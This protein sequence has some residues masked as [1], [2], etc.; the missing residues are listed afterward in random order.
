MPKLEKQNQ[1]AVVSHSDEQLLWPLMLHALRGRWGLAVTMSLI[2]CICGAMILYL[3]LVPN[4]RSEGMIRL[5]PKRVSAFSSG[6]VP[7]SGKAM[8]GYLS[9]QVEDI[10][11]GE[12]IKLTMSDEVIRGE[13][14]SGLAGEVRLKENLSAE[15]QVMS[16]LIRLEY[17]HANPVIAK[18]VVDTVIGSYIKLR[19]SRQA[20]MD[21]RQIELLGQRRDSL[22]NQRESLRELILKMKGDIS[23]SNVQVL[24]DRYEKR[25]DTLNSELSSLEIQLAGVQSVVVTKARDEA[26]ANAGAEVNPAKLAVND[27]VLSKYMDQLVLL[28]IDLGKLED[29]FTDVHPDVITTRNHMGDLR[30]KISSHMKL[31]YPDGKAMPLNTESVM[32]WEQQ[33]ASLQTQVDKAVLLRDEAQVRLDVVAGKIHDE[34]PTQRLDHSLLD[35][36]LKQVDGRVRQLDSRIAQLKLELDEQ[37]LV[38]IVSMGSMPIR[39]L[40]KG[41]IGKAIVGGVLGIILGFG[42]IVILGYRDK[43][44]FYPDQAVYQLGGVP[45]LGVVPRLKMRTAENRAIGLV[46]HCI[47]SIRSRLEFGGLGQTKKALMVASAG[48]GDGKSDIAFS[49]AMSFAAAGSRTLLIDFDLDSFVLSERVRS[50]RDETLGISPVNG[51]F[52]A[53]SGAPLREAVDETDI[54]NLSV[55]MASN[56]HQPKNSMLSV[57]AVKRILSQAEATYD[58]ILIDGGQL[59]F[60]SSA[61]IVASQVDGALLTVSRKQRHPE[62]KRSIDCLRELGTPIAGIVFNY[63]KYNQVEGK[64]L[65]DFN[66]VFEGE[67]SGVHSPTEPK[68]GTLA[69][70]VA[71]NLVNDSGD[72]VGGNNVGVAA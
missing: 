28:E 36:Q 29:K 14:G 18:R 20:E 26:M 19:M 64:G 2:S 40:G 65:S 15:N 49:I 50:L 11:H 52:E 37:S 23:S 68:M 54:P 6:E 33:V 44:C 67:F 42:I 45:V 1:T 10:K 13:L 47:G 56:D 7:V 59:P 25:V 57:K 16:P 58:V 63:A 69:M 46:A 48:G 12:V 60:G 35:T 5:N 61:S 9:S 38:E 30:L 62:I 17:V 24:H 53:I 3:A 31:H 55:L 39:P 22:L 51:L 21:S 34:T 32:S 66:H 72:E 71:V 43:R 8:M 4:Y 70:A 41:R 27:L